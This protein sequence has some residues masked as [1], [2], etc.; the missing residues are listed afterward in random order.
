MTSESDSA[1]QASVRYSRVLTVRHAVV[2]GATITVGLGVFAILGLL[3]QSAGGESL[4]NTYLL[5]AVIAIPL[6]LTL[7][8]R[9]GV[10]P[11]N[12]G[13][14]NIAR[15]EHNIDVA[16]ATGWLL[17]GGYIALAAILSWGAALHVDILLQLF[18]PL[19]IE[20]GW[21]GGCVLLLVGVIRV[22]GRGATLRTRATIVLISCLILLG[23]SLRNF[24]LTT[25]IEEAG[26]Q[27]FDSLGR[28][29]LLAL[30]A[31]TYWGL[32]FIVSN[33]DQIKRPTRAILPSLVLTILLGAVLGAIGAASIHN[34]PS[35]LNDSYTPLIRIPAGFG[36][37]PDAVIQVS[38]AVIGIA[39]LTIALRQTLSYSERQV[40][41]MI[42]DGFFPE[43]LKTRRVSIGGVPVEY[44]LILLLALVSVLFISP[45]II[46]GLAAMMFLWS[47]AAIHLP[48]IFRK[49]PNLPENRRPKLPFHPL[50][51]GLTV[52]IGLFIPTGLGIE[53]WLGGIGWAL[54][55]LALYFLHA[56]RHGIEVRRQLIVVAGSEE[57][58]LTDKACVMICVSDVEELPDLLHT[59]RVLA[60]GDHEEIPKIKVLKTVLHSERS[61]D[62]KRRQ[63]AQEAWRELNAAVESIGVSDVEVESLVRLATVESDGILEA[64]TEEHAKFLL[65]GMDI[66][67]LHQHVRPDSIINTIFKNAVCD[68]GV[69]LGEFPSSIDQAV[70]ATSGGPHAP[71]ALELADALLGE[72]DGRLELIYTV[73]GDISE[74]DRILGEERIA[75]TIASSEITADLHTRIV[76]AP[77]VRDGIVWEA[78]EA[79]LLVIGTSREG[80]FERSFFGGLP[81]QVARLT[82]TPT[83]FVRGIE[84]PRFRLL[85]HIW[86]LLTDFLPTLTPRQ[87]DDVIEDMRSAAIPT[88]D[89]YV[90]MVLAAAIASVGLLQ[91]STAVIIGA[92]LVAPLMNPILAMAMGMVI[93]DLRTLSVGTEAVIKGAT[94]AILVAVLMVVISPIDEPTSEIL[95]RTQPNILDLLVALFSG[96]AAG[97]S[98]SRKEV[99]G[100][101]PGVAIAA[102]LVP[103]LSVVGYG[104]AIANF[105]VAF[106]ALLLFITNL[107]A[108]VLAAAVIFLALNF[109]PARMAMGELRKNLRLTL[110]SLLGISAILLVITAITVRQANMQNELDTI[111]NS[112][113]VSNAAGVQTTDV[114]R[115]GGTYIVDAVILNYVDS[116]LT[117]NAL[118]AV[119][120]ELEE[121]A[122]GP[123]T[124][125]ATIID[126]ERST[127]STDEFFTFARIENRLQEL[128]EGEGVIVIDPVARK[129]G[130]DFLLRVTY[131]NLTD[132]SD[133]D[134]DLIRV[135]LEDEFS[136]PVIIESVIL[137]GEETLIK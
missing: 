80:I 65:M 82:E 136:T 16:Y 32:A 47:S 108:I 103:P 35:P 15:A 119:E 23:I 54:V 46:T 110:F 45:L 10:I 73:P 49:A 104:V 70:V 133:E 118:I 29:E 99:S 40:R 120:Q 44:A 48:D 51:P 1:T 5:A 93:G 109:Q 128:L 87:H 30:I 79:D 114:R 39:I 68:V 69:L 129:D 77:S 4:V 121:A 38:Y 63:V 22:I 83:F 31:S 25:E 67:D 61:T 123:V 135:Q 76:S 2:I 101:L 91:N 102:A 24:A 21:I 28:M 53:T 115:E 75:A 86:G 100:A 95:S 98:V 58:E 8:E 124:I 132:I 137:E 17:I 57:E 42:R 41:A 113:I 127:H 55:G 34:F 85:Q 74:E 60:L 62:R 130:D 122:G 126:A 59:G 19:P 90:L 52:A 20:I 92:M 125:N 116:H 56:R 66:E 12:Y 11:G 71:L 107:I 112:A 97:Y 33:R 134:V 9:L 18:F 27:F 37:I 89:Y 88:V 81:F 131:I 96:L 13:I 106:G 36:I 78:R 3:N 43:V 7:S 6:I 117:A 111:F 14:Y 72:N 50:F 94:M 105:E 26:V 64:I 84:T